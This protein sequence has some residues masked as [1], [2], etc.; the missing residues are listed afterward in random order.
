MCCYDSMRSWW[1][2]TEAPCSWICVV[3]KQTLRSL[4]QSSF[5]R[6]FASSLC[7]SLGMLP[8]HPGLNILL[9]VYVYSSITEYL[10][11]QIRSRNI[12][13]SI[14][15]PNL[16]GKTADQTDAHRPAAAWHFLP[17]RWPQIWNSESFILQTKVSQVFFW[18]F[19]YWIYC[20]FRAI[21]ALLFDHPDAEV[22]KQVQDVF[23]HHSYHWP[24]HYRPP[25][26][27]WAPECII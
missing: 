23:S 18:M 2:T 1:Q 24:G 3:P 9:C 20:L 14:H 15:P 11:P 10:S 7:W 8:N 5:R 22:W 6:C 4:L 13:G 21:D 16:P 12:S 17:V 25:V 19:I 27:L 26:Q